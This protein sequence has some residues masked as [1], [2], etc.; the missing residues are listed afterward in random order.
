MHNRLKKIQITSPGTSPNKERNK[1]VKTLLSG[2]AAVLTGTALIWLGQILGLWWLALVVG[3]LLGIIMSARFA[4]VLALLSGGLGWGLPLLYHS[5]H[6]AI[7][8][9]A[10][11]VA[12]IVGIGSANGWIIIVLTILLGMLLCLSSAWT[13]IALRQV[14]RF[15]L[16]TI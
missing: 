16:P 15:R 14:L 7:G 9:T 11:V 4:L 2:I 3:L 13:G 8:K 6:L 1:A 10:A 12:S 5:T